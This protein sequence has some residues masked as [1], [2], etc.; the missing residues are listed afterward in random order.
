MDRQAG[1]QRLARG[2]AVEMALQDARDP[3]TGDLD[4]VIQ[5]RRGCHAVR[6]PVRDECTRGLD[7]RQSRGPGKKSAEPELRSS[8]RSAYSKGWKSGAVC[9]L[10]CSR[11]PI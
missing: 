3:T 4:L 10:P 5:G 1:N 11:N 7:R 6:T 2:F 9:S 8:E